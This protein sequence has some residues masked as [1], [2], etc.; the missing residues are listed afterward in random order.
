MRYA[1]AIRYQKESVTGEAANGGEEDPGGGD[2]GV[3]KRTDVS[4]NRVMMRHVLHARF[5]DYSNPARK[6][7]SA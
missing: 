5:A 6:V 7:E 4:D 3:L 1:R 2:E